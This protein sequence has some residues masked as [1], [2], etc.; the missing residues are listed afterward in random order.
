MKFKKDAEGKLVLDDDGNPIAVDGD[1][2]VIPL[3]KVVALGKHQ[4]IES[5][6]DEYK[7]EAETLRA[8]IAELQKAGGDKEELEKKLAEITAGSETAKADF[9]ARMA[10]RDKEYAMDT[11]LLGAGVPVGRLKAAKA[12]I[13]T[14]GIAVVNGK[15]DGL[16]LDAFKKDN[17]YLFEASTTVDTGAANR[18]ATGVDKDEAQMRSIMGLPEK[19]E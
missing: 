4:R 18:G 2:N 16:D 7:T 3:D 13:D 8:Q 14:E 10:A 11:A 15:L 19:K 5:E 12:L 1:G 6:R 17:D 9:E